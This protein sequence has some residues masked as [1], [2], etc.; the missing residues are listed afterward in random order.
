MRIKMWLIAGLTA[1]L[2]ACGG[3]GNSTLPPAVPGG[4]A[5]GTV[6]DGLILNGTVTAYDYSSGSKGAVLGQTTTDSATGAYS[7]S[8]QVES[9][10][11]LIEIT[12]GYYTEEAAPTGGTTTVTL[13][14]SDKLTALV[15]YTTGES[16]TVS[17]T[18]YTHLAAG[19]AE[20]E[21]A[22]GVPVAT[23][24]DDANQRVSQFVG[25]DII[26]TTPV[27]ITDVANAS[28]SPTPSI[29]YGFL[30]AAISQWVSA[31]TPAGAAALTQPYTSIK[32][33]QMMHDDVAADGLLDGEGVD[34]NGVKIG[35]SFGTTPLGPTVYRQGIGV[36]LLQIAASANNKTGLTGSNSPSLLAFA[37]AYAANTDKMF[38]AVPAVSITTPSITI[39]APQSSAWVH[40]TIQVSATVQDY[41]GLTSDDLVIDGGNAQALATDLTAPTWSVDTATLPDGP[42]TATVTAT[43]AAGLTSTATVAFLVDN[44]PPTLTVNPSSTWTNAAPVMYCSVSGSISDAASGP[45]STLTASWAGGSTAVVPIVNDAFSVVLS[46]T[47]QATQNVSGTLTI[48]GTDNAGNVATVTRTLAVDITVVGRG[49]EYSGCSI[50]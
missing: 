38:N 44:T 33:D 34:P 42:H 29:E 46:R 32:F 3:G 13:D 22:S 24:I 47:V 40:G 37:E 26:H 1:V 50:Q 12:G 17:V 45:A 2:T 28:A 5:S 41:A 20:Y 25:F 19:L 36:S 49:W 14:A 8:L 23:A 6:L 27:E 18:A 43:N 31:H 48:T 11:I 16:L 7:L 9:R 4:S 35:L 21:I 10:P 15:N 30:A 39:N